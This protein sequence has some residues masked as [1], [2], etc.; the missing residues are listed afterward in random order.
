MSAPAARLYKRP[1][2]V[3][4]VVYTRAGQ[5]LLLKRIEPPD[6]WQSVTGSL[7][8]G[9]IPADTAVRE[10]FEETGIRAGD[11]LRDWRQT[12]TFEILASLRKRYAPGTIHNLEHVYSLQLPAAVPVALNPAEHSEYSWM[13]LGAAAQTVWSW[14]NRAAIEALLNG[15]SAI[16]KVQSSP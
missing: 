2:S 15:G 8:G 11:G 14:T 6:F 1:E 13:G 16:Y 12:N 5:A 9:E 4:V 10:L 7:K 3:L